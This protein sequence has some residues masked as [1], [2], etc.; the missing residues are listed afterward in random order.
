MKFILRKFQIFSCDCTVK[1]LKTIPGSTEKMKEPEMT[2]FGSRLQTPPAM[3][4]QH[5]E[6]SWPLQQKKGQNYSNRKKNY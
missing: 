3:N 5:H 1:Q 6:L 2:S 4:R